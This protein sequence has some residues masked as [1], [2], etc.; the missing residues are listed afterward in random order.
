[1]ADAAIAVLQGVRDVVTCHNGPR[2]GSDF[3]L[4]HTAVLTA[5]LV[6]A[7][8]ATVYAVVRSML[9]DSSPSDET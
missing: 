3:A 2:P 6:A 9:R 7:L 8:R 5:Q 4:W 1:M